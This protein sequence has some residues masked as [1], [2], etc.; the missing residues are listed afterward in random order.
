MLRVLLCVPCFVCPDFLGFR[1]SHLLKSRVLFNRRTKER[2][3]KKRERESAYWMALGEIDLL[4][5]PLPPLT[6]PIIE[7]TKPK[8]TFFTCIAHTSV[9]PSQ[10]SEGVRLIHVYR[11]SQHLS[12][13]CAPRSKGP[14]LVVDER[15]SCKRRAEKKKRRRRKSSKF[16]SRDGG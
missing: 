16:E 3:K 11:V 6:I 14:G 10:T 7:F 5:L 13:V 15:K 1:R 12:N 8:N 2:K 4:L 9:S